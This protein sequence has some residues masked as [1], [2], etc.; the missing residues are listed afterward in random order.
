[1][2]KTAK[3]APAPEVEA[4][5]AAAPEAQAPETQAP[6]AEAPTAQAPKKVWLQ[7]VHG[8]MLHLYTNVLFT[9]EPKQHVIDDFVRAQ[10]ETG[11]LVEFTE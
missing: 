11:K 2:S 5:Q 3:P 1:M 7:A 10:L 6:E 8:N 4:P 9:S